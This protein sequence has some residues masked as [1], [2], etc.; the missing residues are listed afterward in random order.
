MPFAGA[1]DI[2]LP[3]VAATDG[4]ELGVNAISWITDPVTVSAGY[5]EVVTNSVRVGSESVAE[6]V[7]QRSTGI[8]SDSVTLPPG[9]HQ[10]FGRSGSPPLCV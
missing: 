5:R 6:V 2:V 8:L 4:V 7:L 10:V 3:V 1:D 9:C